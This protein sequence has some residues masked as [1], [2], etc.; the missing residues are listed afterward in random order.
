MSTREGSVVL[1]S[2]FLDEAISR[3]REKVDA[4]CASLPEE[5][6]ESIA[7][8]IGIGAVKFDILR[9]A[10]SSNITFDWETA[11]AFEGSSGPYV[12]YSCARISSILRK[13]GKEV[14]DVPGQFPELSDAEAPDRVSAALRDRNSSILTE[15]SIDL[16]Q[17]F[18]E[19]YHKC[20]VLQAGTEDTATV[21]LN[22]CLATRQVLQTVLSLLG[23]NAPERM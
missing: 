10:P 16:A 17:R 4:S 8:T 1:L 21:R 23:I 15:Y 6:R 13:Y 22:I 12:Q 2:D 19:F 7:S 18:T 14:D 3:A 9:V 11:L 5:E 20:P